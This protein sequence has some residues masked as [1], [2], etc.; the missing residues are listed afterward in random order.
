LEVEDQEKVL[1]LLHQQVQVVLL[2][3]Q[4]LHLQV[5]EQEEMLM[6]LLE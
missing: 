6:P 1:H 5:E 3:F 4:Q 2:F